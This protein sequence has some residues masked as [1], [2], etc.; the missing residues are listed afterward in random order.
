MLVISISGT[1]EIISNSKIMR[2][3]RG[4]NL[5]YRKLNTEM[6]IQAIVSEPTITAAA[7]KCGVSQQSIYKYMKDPEFKAE[8]NKKQQEILK[9]SNRKMMQATSLAADKLISVLKDPDASNSDIIRTGELV[10]KV[11]QNAMD[12][13]LIV[14]KLEELE[15]QISSRRD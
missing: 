2:K 3:K 11:S 6:M 8:L 10:F 13:E 9:E 15:E 7:A 14:Q 1:A 12:S 5:G 4:E